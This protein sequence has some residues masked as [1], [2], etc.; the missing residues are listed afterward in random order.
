MK[1]G[2]VLPPIATPFKNEKVINEIGEE[3]AAARN[4]EYL[5]TDLLSGGKAEIWKAT[6]KKTKELGLYRQKYCG[7][8]WSVKV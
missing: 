3:I 1:R 6:I 2:G 4:L 8:E 7:C 5:A